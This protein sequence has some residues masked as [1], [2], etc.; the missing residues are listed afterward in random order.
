MRDLDELFEALKKSKFRAG[1]K[2]S[3]KDKKYLDQKG[4]AVIL[5]H[6]Q[7]FVTERL[8]PAEP[9]N[10]GKQTPMKNHPV[11]TAQHATAVCCRKCLEKWHHIPKYKPLTEEHIQY[12]IN[13]IKRW[14][15][16]QQ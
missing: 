14:L 12:I 1:F 16:S 10:D 8:A 4:L 5:D 13:V 2:L 9:I 3:A 6:A 11:F 15:I 7:K